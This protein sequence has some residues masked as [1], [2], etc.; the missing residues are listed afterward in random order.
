MTKPF[1]SFDEF[2]NPIFGKPEPKVE[3]KI[4]ELK[5]LGVDFYSVERQVLLMTVDRNWID[6]IDAMDQLRKGISLR[7]YGQVD[8][9]VEYKKEGFELFDIMV[10]EIQ[11]DVCRIVLNS[12]ITVERRTPP[13]EPTYK[14]VEVIE[15]GPVGPAKA[16]STVGRNDLCPCGSGQKY[17]NCCGK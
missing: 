3:K 6:H 15:N 9:V 13:T 1:D 7:S 16:E 2:P 10:E 4:E 14:P 17:K 8:P 5:A 11:E 12:T